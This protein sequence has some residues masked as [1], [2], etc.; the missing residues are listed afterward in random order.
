MDTRWS[1]GL[2]DDD[3]V[4]LYEPAKYDLSDGLAMASSYQL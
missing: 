2:W 1:D 4:A 3:D